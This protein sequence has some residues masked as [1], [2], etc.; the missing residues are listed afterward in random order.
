MRVR[1]AV[2]AGVNRIFIS[3]QENMAA[4]AHWINMGILFTNCKLLS[5]N[6]ESVPRGESKA[7]TYCYAKKDTHYKH[8]F[9]S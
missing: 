8:L 1:L 7:G 4:G 3:V 5:I 2:A 6:S 9:I